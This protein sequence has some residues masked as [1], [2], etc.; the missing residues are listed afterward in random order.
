[1]SINE[2]RDFFFKKYY[3]QIGF[4]K[5]SSY[6]SMKNIKK[7]YLLLFASQLVENIPDPLNTKGHYGPFIIKKNGKSVDI[8]DIKSISTE[9]SETSHKLPKTI[10]QFE[11][12]GSD[13]SLYSDT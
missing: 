12:V 13:S 8:V 4:S 5:E 2:N 9:H 10:G 7:K 11:K 3:K 1:M 6:Y